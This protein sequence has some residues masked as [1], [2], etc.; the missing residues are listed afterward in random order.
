MREKLYFL[1]PL[2]GGYAT[3]TFENE[4]GEWRKKHEY[5]IGDWFEGFKFEVQS[6]KE[7]YEIL[8]KNQENNV[9]LV[10]GEFIEGIDTNAMIRRQRDGNEDGLSPTIRNRALYCV[11]IDVDGYE[12]ELEN[13]IKELPPEFHKADY[14]RQFSASYA[15][16]EPNVLKCHLWF[17]FEKAVELD[18]LR[19]W[20]QQ[21]NEEKGWKNL[22]DWGIYKGSQPI[23]IKRRTCIGAPDPL[24]GS[25][26]KLVQKKG[27]VKGDPI[28]IRQTRLKRDSAR[29]NSF[30]KPQYNI[31]EGIQKVLKSENYHDELRGM[32]LSLINKKVPPKVV[33]DMLKGA[34]QSVKSNEW[35]K[36]EAERWQNRFD[37]IERSVDS[38]VKIVNEPTLEELYEWIEN[39]SSDDDYKELRLDFANK[40]FKLPPSDTSSYVKRIHKKIGAGVQGIRGDILLKRKEEKRKEVER[41]K[42][43]RSEMRKKLGITEI[44]VKTSN[45]NKV[46]KQCGKL[47]A[48]SKNG[49]EVFHYGGKLAF[50]GM[51]APATIKQV[52]SK[53]IL[54]ADY[55]EMPT[56]NSFKKPYHSLAAR[57]EKDAVFLNQSGREIEC[58]PRVL[59]VL[60][61]AL[62]R[63]FRPLVGVVE[64]PF[65]DD[66]FKLVRK[67][68]YDAQTGLYT[69]L[70]RR[71]KV[72]LGDPKEAYDFLADEL[73][74]EFPFKSDLDRILAVAAL[75]TVAQR[76]AL[77]GDNNGMPGFGI[78]S[79]VQSSGKTTLAQ[80]ISYSIFNRPIPASSFSF[81]EDEM[82]KRIVAILKEGHSFVLFDNIKEHSN[83]ESGKVSAA[84]SSDVFLGRQLGFNEMVK[85]PSS[86]VWMFTGNNINFVGDFATRV[87]KIR[88][89]PAVADPEQRVFKR[90]DLGKW[91]LKNRSRI[92]SSV[93]SVVMAGK[94]EIEIE[95]SC[96]FKFWD[97]FV[98]RPLYSLTGIDVNEAVKENKKNDSVHTAKQHLLAMLYVV[99]K[100][101]WF[102][103]KEIIDKAYGSF[104]GK[105]GSVKTE[106]AQSLEDLI[107]KNTQNALSLARY[108]SGMA[109]TVFEDFLLEKKHSNRISWRVV[110]TKKHESH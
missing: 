36:E 102:T 96:R 97:K 71:I 18:D 32:S 78:T 11:C 84:M 61:D 65:L 2:D 41:A 66:D 26:I 35:G 43:Y 110:R 29:R 27:L 73:F 47:L 79:P 54:G 1:R 19:I 93:L 34:M 14:I 50:V 24:I 62:D 87:Y 109:E 8:E 16:T 53:R 46:I 77:A 30:N 10:Q 17:W 55:P 89:A 92:I 67:A 12:G 31:K 15:L 98:R 83:V 86:V 104:D 38:A 28:K 45:A 68:G 23:Y 60:G 52:G 108:L 106:L 22:I 48:K 85:V 39:C 81:D 94:N 69:V 101:E 63:S 82:E 49:D 6:L 21:Y 91:T 20:A 107:S 74:D 5:T 72:E 40:G 13:F 99:F 58:P 103:T 7:V 75:M 90:G 37:D 100:E 95:G 88:I 51:S 4:N 59:H 25:F 9:F 56:I 76:P 57:L 80:L 42:I 44:I 105:S 3:K 70:N 64:N 33:K